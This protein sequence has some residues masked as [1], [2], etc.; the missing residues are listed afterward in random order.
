MPRL[1]P[2]ARGALLYRQGAKAPAPPKHLRAEAKALWRTITH[3]YPVDYF[4]PGA[5]LLL[6]SFVE[7]VLMRRFYASLLKND[8]ASPEYLKAITMLA[9]SMNQTAQKLR[10][11]NSSRLF[12]RSGILDEVDTK[13][14][15]EGDNVHRLLFG[16][17]EVRY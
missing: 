3:A 14:I 8:P 12:K 5:D 7:T 17:G 13:P 1:S 11:A 4:Q 2:E 15:A 10:L 9:N 16:N 6:E